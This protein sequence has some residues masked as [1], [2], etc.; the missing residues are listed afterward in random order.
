M[1]IK[2]KGILSVVSGF[3]GAG[4]GSI[5]KELLSRHKSYALSISATT[6][7]PRQGEV[8]GREYFFKTVDQFEKM[9]A[10]QEL[11]EYAKYVDNYYGTPKRYVEEQ[12]LA[13]K[14]IILEIEMQGAL[15]IKERF[16]D[17]LL[18]FV[19]PPSAGELKKRL[20]GRGTETL[21]VIESRMRRALEEAEYMEQYDYLIINDKLEESAEEVHRIIQ[22][23]HARI[24][25]QRGF[26][27]NIKQDLEQIL[28]GDN[29]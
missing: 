27:S 9:I 22:S 18:L 26:I 19:A 4:K 24:S 23:A 28:K 20:T 11:I 29:R 25:F 6:R 13:G 3:S 17:A 16:P 12:L 2:E 5:M 1:K 8:D 21:E 14:D 10:N 15:Q 7:K